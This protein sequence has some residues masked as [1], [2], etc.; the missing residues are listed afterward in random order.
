MKKH[1]EG[2]GLDV[3]AFDACLASDRYL[4]EIDKDSEEAK[5]VRITGTP[6]F[7]VGRSGG[8][9]L[10]GK[11]VVGAQPMNVFSAAIN[12]VLDENKDAKD[13]AAEQAKPGG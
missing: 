6:T 11:L 1:A 8:D 4:A 5:R 3:S 2:L 9:K 13:P 12:N 10:S 7:V